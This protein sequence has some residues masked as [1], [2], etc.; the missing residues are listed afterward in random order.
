MQYDYSM[1]RAK[2]IEKYRTLTAFCK[3]LDITYPSLCA[4]M[5]SKRSFTQREIEDCCQLLKIPK[6]KIGYYFFTK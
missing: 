2:I 3:A 6:S 1:L 4:K 5:H